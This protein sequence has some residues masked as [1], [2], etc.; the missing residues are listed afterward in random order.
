M[1]T[2]K[3]QYR[4]I[5]DIYSPTVG[6]LDLSTGLQPTTYNVNRCKNAIV[7]EAKTNI[8]GQ[9]TIADRGLRPLLQGGYLNSGDR[10]FIFDAK[11]L[12]KGFIIDLQQYFVYNHIRYEVKEVSAFSKN[13]A[14]IAAATA[15][16]TTPPNEINVLSVYDYITLSDTS[17][18]LI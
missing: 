1:Y 15:T 17:G 16:K 8:T 6:E 18:G 10:I 3:R 11:D 4:E 5:V 14:Y 12:P 13:L 9:F 2:L 7:L